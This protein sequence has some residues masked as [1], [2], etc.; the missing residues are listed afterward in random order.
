MKNILTKVVAF[1]LATVTLFSL[2]ACKPNHDDA[3]T[4]K[5]ILFIGDGMGPNHVYNTELYYEEQ[6]YFSSFEYI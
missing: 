1:L 3:P 4:S 5:V 6:M 2:T